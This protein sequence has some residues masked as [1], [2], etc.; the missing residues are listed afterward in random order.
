MKAENRVGGHNLV[1]ILGQGLWGVPT[2]PKGRV[3]GL[4]AGLGFIVV[5][6]GSAKRPSTAAL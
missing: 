6:A 2:G 3:L 5:V 4:T 1:L